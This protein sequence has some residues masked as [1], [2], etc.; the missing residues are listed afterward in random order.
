MTPRP[1]GRT[2]ACTIEQAPVRLGQARALLEVAELVGDDPDDLATP[3][4]A[5]ALAVLAGMAAADAAC[6]A[7]LGRRSRGDHR[8]A[9]GLLAEV[10]PS[11]PDLA[12]ALDR[13]LDVKDGAHY[14]MVY[15]SG[16]K[17]AAVRQARLLL[18][19]ASSLVRRR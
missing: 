7:A 5:A 17:V 18:E 2:Q 15:V 11:G 12:R 13:L 10:G 1:A 8:Q 16:Q 9:A 6:C 14:G 19:A 3:G 4:V